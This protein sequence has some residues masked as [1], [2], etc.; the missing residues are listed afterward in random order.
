MEPEKAKA[1]LQYPPCPC[2]I[3]LCVLIFMYLC[4]VDV[5]CVYIFVPCEV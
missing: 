2:G 5:S 4:Q 1:N 3:Y